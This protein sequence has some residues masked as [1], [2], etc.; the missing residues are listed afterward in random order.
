MAGAAVAFIRYAKNVF[1][2]VEITARVGNGGRRIVKV[3]SV[4]GVNC[5]ARQAGSRQQADRHAGRL[6]NSL[7]T[8]LQAKRVSQ[9]INVFPG[10]PPSHVVCVCTTCHCRWPDL[11]LRLH[12]EHILVLPALLF[13][14][15]L[16][17]VV[18]VSYNYYF[19]MYMWTHYA[20]AA[21]H[22]LM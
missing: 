1:A 3:V 14:L 11:P 13:V 7:S 10:L 2:Q 4:V 8:R 6:A 21:W 18:A 19:H 17:L 9:P 12:R 16:L 20:Y 5:V 15:L 22:K